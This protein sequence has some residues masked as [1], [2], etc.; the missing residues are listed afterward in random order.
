MVARSVLDDPAKALATPRRTSRARRAV[1]ALIRGGGPLALGV[2][3]AAVLGVLLVAGPAQSYLDARERVEILALKERALDEE[4]A[5]LEQR[6]ADL[7]DP[8]HLELVAREQLGL[9][10]PGEIAYTIIPPDSESPRFAT[11]P[12]VEPD[13]PSLLER[14]RGLVRRV[15]AG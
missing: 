5:R 13:T 14:L 9:V 4:N 11:E 12:V 2:L 1:R 7:H 10:R 8:D 3:V 15:A 6:I